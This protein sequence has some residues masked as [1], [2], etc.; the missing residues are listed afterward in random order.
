[1]GRATGLRKVCAALCVVAA[2]ATTAGAQD[3][4]VELVTTGPASGGSLAEFTAVSISDDGATVAFTSTER[5]VTGDEDDQADV[6]VRRAGTTSLASL[7]DKGGNNEAFP[8]ASPV[9]SQDGT[10]VYFTTREPLVSEDADT[11]GD[12]Y[13]WIDGTTRLVSVR[14]AGA[15]GAAADVGLPGRLPPPPGERV[16]VETKEQMLTA[17]GDPADNDLYERAGGTLR[18]LTGNSDQDAIALDANRALTHVYFETAKDLLASDSDGKQPDTYM[19]TGEQIF[20]VSRAPA[21]NSGGAGRNWADLV[22]ADGTRAFLHTAEGLDAGDT[23][24][25]LDTYLW[26][27]DGTL[28]WV[29]KPAGGAGCARAACPTNTYGGSAD[30]GRV[31]FT[32]AERLLAGDTDDAIDVYAWSDGTL[33]HVSTGPNG[34]NG[35]ADTGESPA[36]RTQKLGSDGRG[37]LFTTGEALTAEDTDAAVDLYERMDGT[38]RLVSTGELSNSGG[39]QPGTGSYRAGSARA[40][41]VSGSSLARADTD[42]QLDVYLNEAGATRLVSVGRAAYDADFIAASADAARI[43]FRTREQLAA[44]DLDGGRDLYSSRRLPAPSGGAPAA[45]TTAPELGLRVTRKTFRAANRRARMTA[46]RRKRPIGTFIDAY[47][48]EGGQVNMT[49]SKLVP[50][51]RAGKGRC[52]PTKRRVRKSLRC[53][54]PVP[55]AGKLT[56]GV[57]GGRNRIRFYGRVGT[58]KLTPGRYA[59]FA[60]TYDA[61]GNSSRIASATFRIVR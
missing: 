10:R 51:R 55:Q 58:R 21:A 38:T 27:S 39:V 11:A 36:G 47:V 41:F 57:Q 42:E 32:T 44:D 16:I 19:V 12:V 25:Q 5:L 61:A 9:V 40:I 20:H 34:G 15:P 35:A 49:F 50:G 18:L 43:F 29:S 6:Y 46:K 7:G 14:E 48:S 17:D 2:T 31:A 3:R 56:F 52:V 24:G 28:R 33:E 8:A 59:V 45:D 26:Q 54:K 4:A 53:T 30:L 13:E 60:R 23:D 37:V 22:S 1:M